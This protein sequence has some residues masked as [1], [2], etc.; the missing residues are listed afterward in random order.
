M[1]SIQVISTIIVLLAGLVC[2]AFISQTLRIKKE[3]RER[4]MAMLK[5]R[6]NTFKFMLNGFPK[7]FL[8]KE[9]TLLVQR[10]LIETCEQLTKLDSSN[11]TYQQDLQIV[12][13]QMTE[14]QRQSGPQ[15]QKR[16]DNQQQVKEV[17]MCL[18][19]LYRFIH[20]QQQKNLLPKNQAY[21][22]SAQIKQLVLQITVDSYVLRG[23]ASQQSEKYKL[24]YHYYDLAIKLL[25]REGKAGANDERIAELKAL[26]PPLAIKMAEEEG[27]T[28]LSEQEMAE[29]TEMDNEWDKFGEKEDFWKKKHA[30]D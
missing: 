15:P 19:E 8:P 21:A 17:K 2:Y 16:L 3:Q 7:G 28:N 29:Q 25:V 9:L 1:S 22:F 13:G 4:L 6:N 11:P 23:V 24:A 27:T 14:T 12:S 20:N 26:L 18:E 10:S 5:R 30:Y